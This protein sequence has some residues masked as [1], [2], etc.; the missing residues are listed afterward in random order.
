MGS[1]EL[2]YCFSSDPREA[3]RIALTATVLACA[4]PGLLPAFRS[5]FQAFLQDR[6]R[7]NDDD[8]TTTDSSLIDDLRIL[9]WI[10]PNT[11]L[12]QQPLVQAIHQ[13]IFNK[14]KETIAGD[15]ET[16]GLY[17][18]VTNWK[19]EHVAT[20]LAELLK[21]E[22]DDCVDVDSNSQQETD[23]TTTAS[24]N[25]WWTRIDAVT[26][27]CYCLVRMEEIFDMV[28]DYP[29]SHVAV[30]ELRTVLETTKMHHQ[31]GQ[32]LRHS[33]I[34][35]LNH[36]GANTSQIIDVYIATIKVLRIIDPSDLLLSLVAEPVR[37]YLRGRAD[38]VR[39]IIT[40]LTD[41]EVGGDLYEELRR[42][43]A[44][45]LENVTV[46]SDDED[47][48]PDFNWQPPPS[49]TKPRGTFLEA[50]MGGA[51]ERSGEGDILAMLVSIYGSKEL[52]V[53]EYRLMLAD[54]LLANLDY[55][56]DK[57]V[58][59]LEL[60]KL[61]FGEISMRNCE[62]MIKDM[63]DSKRTNTNIQSTLEA[64]RTTLRN[65]PRFRAAPNAPSKP[66]VDVAMISHIFWPT[67]QN[68]QLKHH[69]RIQSELDEFSTEYARLKNPR[70]LVWFDQLGTVQLELDVIEEG[71]SDGQPVVETRE[72]SCTP[73]HATLISHF[74]DK[75][76]WTVSELSNETGVAEH[77]VQRRMSYWVTNR[78]VRLVTNP[79]AAV[80]SL[81]G[82]LATPVYQIA[83]HAHLQERD[84]AMVDNVSMMDDEDG[85]V[86][87]SVS[88]TAQEQ[89]EMEVYESYIVGMLTNLQQLP[90]DRIHNMLK[91]FVTGSD[92]RYNKT[93]QQLSTFLQHLCKQEKLE[94]GP[95]GMYKLFKK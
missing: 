55:N 60:L 47:E 14:V 89:E 24:P 30:A 67:L 54:K 21:E 18:Q 8:S 28:A 59:T 4:P 56:T 49:I 87:Q 1:I 84:K 31:L 85:N 38:T 65:N 17:E 82:S 76:E 15:Y 92:V 36:P 50:S 25:S 79:I 12:L 26:A 32:A 95:G 11:G 93:P 3:R 9:G 69:P 39:C 33:L 7:G 46:D 77:I 22:D 51:T 19:D 42:Q 78:V 16:E 90:L 35:R 88:V 86:G 94:C 23:P 2:P 52:F 66:V 81:G 13:A 6:Q 45:P 40:S 68:D 62:V 41:A 27:E 58:H 10:R 64:R 20:W 71:Q 5:L 53:N 73:F 48:C 44:K 91:T 75:P 63:Y 43:D 80:A 57:E 37:S 61:R 34:R 29:D 70:K 74:E 72:F 83:T